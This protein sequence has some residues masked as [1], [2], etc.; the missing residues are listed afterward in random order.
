MPAEVFPFMDHWNIQRQKISLREIMSEELALQEKEDQVRCFSN[1]SLPGKI[2]LWGRTLAQV[3][4]Q[5]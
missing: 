4:M 2:N 5:C 3:R 1:V